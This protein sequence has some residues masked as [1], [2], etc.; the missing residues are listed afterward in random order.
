MIDTK[1]PHK[2]GVLIDRWY[3]YKNDEIGTNGPMS[4]NL[5]G[6]ACNLSKKKVHMR[7]I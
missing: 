1:E 6:D 7:H 5:K 4:R 2:Q 3:E